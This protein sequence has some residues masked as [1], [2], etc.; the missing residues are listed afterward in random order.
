[1]KPWLLLALGACL[2]AGIVLIPAFLEHVH[3][4][5]HDAQRAADIAHTNVTF[6]FVAKGSMAAVAPLFGA[7]R[8]RVW[9]PGWQPDVLWPTDG[10][11]RSGMIFTVP[12]GHTQAVWVNTRLDLSNGNVQYVY[13]VPETLATVITI[14]MRPDHGSAH[15]TVTY[16][17]TALTAGANARV[18]QLAEHDKQAG[19]EWQHQINAFL[20]S[21]SRAIKAQ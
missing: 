9:A 15:V 21:G 5:R 17:R 12:H 4:L 18:L 20:S 2:G 6:S 7:G 16:D 13:V 19:R 10:G 1:M 3:S 8:E 14:G 11:D